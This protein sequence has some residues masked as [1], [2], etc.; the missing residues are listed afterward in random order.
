[1]KNVS[2]NK[3]ALQAS[4]TNFVSLCITIVGN[5]HTVREDVI[6]PPAKE[7]T[8]IMCEEKT[9][10]QQLSNDSVSH[11]IQDMLKIPSCGTL[12]LWA[13]FKMDSLD[14]TSTHLQVFTTSHLLVHSTTLP[15][16]FL[17]SLACNICIPPSS[18][19]GLQ[20]LQQFLDMQETVF[21]DLVP[22]IF[23]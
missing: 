5:L 10:K 11:R 7:L 17:C 12:M 9:I 20:C 3:K 15:S 13:M 14:P 19:P 4:Q 16:C 6:L 21:W 22:C 23:G 1:M 18:T 2:S 8:L